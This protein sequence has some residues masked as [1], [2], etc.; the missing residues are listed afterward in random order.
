MLDALTSGRCYKPA[1]PLE[2]ASAYLREGAGT[3][4]DPRC[5]ELLLSQDQEI[6]GIMKRFAEGSSEAAS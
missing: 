6:L 3:Q 1:W 2:K 4:F 5:V